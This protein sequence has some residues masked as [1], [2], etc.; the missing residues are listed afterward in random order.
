LIPAIVS[1]IYGTGSA[2]RLIVGTL[3]GHFAMRIWGAIQAYVKGGDDE[4]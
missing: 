2:L 3:L 1:A 4:E